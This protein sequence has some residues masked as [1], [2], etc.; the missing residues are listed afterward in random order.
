MIDAGVESPLDGLLGEVRSVV[1]GLDAGGL[2]VAVGARVVEQCAEAERWLAALRVMVAAGLKDAVFWRRE[3]FRSVAAWMAAKT[4]TAVGPAVEAL[5][6]A[7][8]LEDLA[9]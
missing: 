4:G 2:D 6:M 3:G 7:G 9:Q 8:Q 1:G 5:E